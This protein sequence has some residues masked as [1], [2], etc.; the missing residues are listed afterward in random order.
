MVCLVPVLRSQML[1]RANNCCCVDVDPQLKNTLH[2]G[3][4][5]EM[6]AEYTLLDTG[7]NAHLQTQTHVCTQ[8]LAREFCCSDDRTCALD[9]I[10][11]IQPSYSLYYRLAYD[12]LQLHCDLPV[13]FLLMLSCHHDISC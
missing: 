3:W 8:H 6:Q 4:Q 10:A 13:W 1:R 9:Q 11:W 2:V 12:D 5:H 7:H